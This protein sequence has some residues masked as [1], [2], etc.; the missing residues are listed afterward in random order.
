MSHSHEK[1]GNPT[2]VKKINLTG[3]LIS[4]T[5]VLFDCPG[6]VP[7]VYSRLFQ[8]QDKRRDGPDSSAKTNIARE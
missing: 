1:K 8:A 7:R 4:R 6:C 2:K 3:G 5:P